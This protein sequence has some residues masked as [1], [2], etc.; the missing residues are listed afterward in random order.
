MKFPTA[1]I[2]IFFLAAWLFSCSSVKRVGDDE[3]LLVKNSI[4]IDSSKINMRKVYDQLAQEPNATLPLINYPLRLHIYNA[5]KPDPDSI[6]Y[7]WLYKRP[8]REERLVKLLSKKQVER[9]GQNY[10]NWQGFKERMGEEPTIVNEDKT[11]KSADRLRA[12]Y[13]NLG[14]FN[15][16]TSYEV[17]T[18]KGKKAEVNYYVKRNAPYSIDSLSSR[19]QSKVVDSLFQHYKTTSPLRKGDQFEARRFEWE[20]NR[21]TRLFRN[22]GLY[23][24]DQ[25]YITFNADTINT[26][27]KVNIETVIANREVSQ[28]DTTFTV[29]FKVRKVSDVYVFTNYID[30]NH[31][32][33]PITDSIH[34]NDFTLFSSGK[35][36]YKSKALT[37]AIFIKK[38]E[39][40]KDSSRSF[41]YDRMN[42]IGIF[43]YPD[44]KFMED[45]RDSTNTDLIAS[46]FLKSRKKFGVTYDLDVSRSNIQDFGIRIGGSL[47]V[48]NVFNG[49]E[50]LEIGL[51]GS[52]GSSQDASVTTKDRFFNISEI[53]ADLKLNFPKII[54]PLA[55]EGVIPKTMSPFTTLGVGISTQHNIGLDKQNLTGKFSYRWNHDRER[56]LFFNLVDLQYVRNLNPSNYFNIY[57]NSFD[58]LNRIAKSHV[59]H[60]NP[61]YFE[62]ANPV[63]SPSPRLTIPD[64]AAAFMNDLKQ[65]VDFGLDLLEIEETNTL[66]ERRDRLTENNLIFGSSF[67]YTK[68]TRQSIYDDDFTQFRFHLEAVGNTLALFSRALGRKKAP[69]GSY[70]I[71]G[72]RFSQYLKA[73]ADLI[74]HWDLGRRNVFAVKALAGIAVPYGNANSIPFVR[75]FFAGGSNDNRGWRP[76]DLGPGSSGGPNEFNEANM[77]LSF[78]AEY[79]F[80]LFGQL[81]SALFVDVGNIWNVSDNVRDERSR[82]S[83]LSDLKELAVGSG[84]GLRYDFE[85][86]VIRLDFGFK[87]YNPAYDKQKWF[88]DYNLKHSVLNVGINYPF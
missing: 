21:L 42:D 85:F 4:Y 82:F 23:Y 80:N 59:L 47:L 56:T 26:G 30:N 24:F 37:D 25:E 68:N 20:R 27:H 72:V 51:R 15:T 2:L 49:L 86:F 73:E 69:D 61:D 11:Q 71:S 12:Y 65:G 64:G 6:F 13:W 44:I 45:P 74:K 70:H 79:R 5:A 22:N 52:I 58:R 35:P 10:V 55:T 81:N 36:R 88:Q 14:W 48:R 66:I 1:K 75:S 83:S 41:T 63:L 38:G 84:V 16:E 60:I 32:L 3:Y 62:Q 17:D 7:Q 46:V 50:T 18:L 43:Q 77:K 76:Y 28:K 29:P 8:K 19:I 39:V 87:T 40:Y 33:L 57:R 54:F 67:D 53:G 31:R 78:N 34:Y 9:L